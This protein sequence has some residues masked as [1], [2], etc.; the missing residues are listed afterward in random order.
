[1]NHGNGG[2]HGFTARRIKQTVGLEVRDLDVRDATDKDILTLASLLLLHVVVVVREQYLSAREHVAFAGR[3]GQLERFPQHASQYDGE[4]WRDYIFPVANHAN[5]GHTRVGLYWHTD[6]YFYHHPTAVSIMRPVQLPPV[7]GATWFANMAEACKSL[8]PE[9]LEAVNGRVATSHP[10]P[11]RTHSA[12]FGKTCLAGARHRLVRP[13]PLHK[14][15][16]LFLN[17]HNIA[18]IDGL[19]SAQAQSLVADLIAHVDRSDSV[20]CHQWQPGDLVMWDNAGG[21]HKA[22]TPDIQ[23]ERL[24]ERTTLV[25][26]EYYGS[27][28]W[29]AAARLSSGA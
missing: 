27:D 18:S 14:R 19:T 10:V 21:A 23:Y 11:Q 2:K 13:H 26:D 4:P 15:P 29:Q 7:G 20:Y 28:L 9:L 17:P 5:Q 24:M 1:M 6:G 12:G 3:F 16:V 8:P 22:S 25:G